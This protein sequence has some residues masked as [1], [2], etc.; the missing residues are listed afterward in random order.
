MTFAKLKIARLISD[1]I[2]TMGVSD[3]PDAEGIASMLEY[4]PSPDKGD[5]AFPCFRLSKA[6][7]KAPPMIAASIKEALASDPLVCG[8]ETAGG[9]LNF[10]LDK[11]VFAVTALKEMLEK[12]E[13]FGGS[14]EGKG[15]TVVLDYSSPNICKPFHIGHLGTTVI[16]HSIKKLHEFSGYDCVGINYL[17]DWGT[18]F[19]KL[20]VAYRKWGSKEEVERGGI[21]VLVDLYVRINHAIDGD[22]DKGI[23]GNKALAS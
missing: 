22:P 23:E 20:M 6:M 19:G 12:K 15:K 3:A 16:G 7:R 5:L 1:A 17:G 10:F 8:I 18:Q 11:S 21:D 13:R 2:G 4:P 14:D 9:Y